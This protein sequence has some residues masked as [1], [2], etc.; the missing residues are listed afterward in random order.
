MAAEMVSSVVAQETVSQIL[1]GLV[2]RY[3]ES[4]DANRKF[5]RLEMAHIRQDAALE[6][7]DKW[8]IRTPMHPCCTGERS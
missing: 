2:K 4:N 3:T 8:Q 6:T 5:E 1:S 7:S